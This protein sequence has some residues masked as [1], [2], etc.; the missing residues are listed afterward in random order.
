MPSSHFSIPSPAVSVPLYSRMWACIHTFII[1]MHT[2][3]IC[4][5]G[6][7]PLRTFFFSSFYLIA[8]DRCNVAEFE[9]RTIQHILFAMNNC[10]WITANCELLFVWF[11][12]IDRWEWE[13]ATIESY[14]CCLIYLYVY[15]IHMFRS[16]CM[17]TWHLTNWMADNQMPIN[18]HISHICAIKGYP[19]QRHRSNRI[20]LQ[21][22][23][24]DIYRMFSKIFL[25]ITF[26][27]TCSR[28]GISPNLMENKRYC[29]RFITRNHLHEHFCCLYLILI[30]FMFI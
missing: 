17:H 18:M 29:G 30:I 2:K 11:V 14:N 27:V 10:N 12:W 24:L 8:G 6:H 23:H 15:S 5:F 4:G 3:S 20:T 28:I 19:R 16:C 21:L 26:H 25:N 1:Y 9:K 13:H 22:F 7:T